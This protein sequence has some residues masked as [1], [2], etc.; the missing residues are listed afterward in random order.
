MARAVV[1]RAEKRRIVEELTLLHLGE[2]SELEEAVE[3]SS[4]DFVAAR[5]AR[6]YATI[7]REAA[8]D[9]AADQAALAAILLLADI[10]DSS[11]AVMYWDALCPP[12]CAWVPCALSLLL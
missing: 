12:H 10:P 7:E 8:E 3:L 4:G 11:V 1:K 6:E 2:L 9:T 5:D